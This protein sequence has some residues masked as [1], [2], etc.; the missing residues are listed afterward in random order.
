MRR[1]YVLNNSFYCLRSLKSSSVFTAL[2]LYALTNKSKIVLIM[3][4][5]LGSISSVMSLVRLYNHC[6]LS[7]W[8]ELLMNSG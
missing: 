5:L 2:R 7:T 6:V 4:L 1:Q 3:V 8:L